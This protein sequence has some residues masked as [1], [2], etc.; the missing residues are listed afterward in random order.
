MQLDSSDA[1]QILEHLRSKIE[2]VIELD[3][4]LVFKQYFTMINDDLEKLKSLCLLNSSFLNRL[5]E[6]TDSTYLWS[7]LN[8]WT[9]QIESLLKNDAL[10]VKYLLNKIAYSIGNQL[11]TVKNEEKCQALSKFYHQKLEFLL[12]KVIQVREDI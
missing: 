1:P 11:E 5:N 6:Q 10:S 9:Q 2:E 12:R 8:L 4:Q 3:V 7:S